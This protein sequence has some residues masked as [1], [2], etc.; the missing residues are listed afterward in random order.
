MGINDMNSFS[1]AVTAMSSHSDCSVFFSTPRDGDNGGPYCDMVQDWPNECNYHGF[2][3]THHA[4]PQCADKG[5]TRTKVSE[6]C[7]DRCGHYRDVYGGYDQEC[8]A[9]V[10]CSRRIS[11]SLD[12]YVILS[13]S[14][15]GSRFCEHSQT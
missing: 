1:R 12:Q 7:C 4:D 13:D 9:M 5:W 14:S 6:C 10:T 11:T 8:G 3:Q 2:L 15:N